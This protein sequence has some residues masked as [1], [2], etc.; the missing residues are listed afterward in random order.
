[1]KSS[2][3]VIAVGVALSLSGCSRP[4]IP[5][6]GLSG[7]PSPSG[8]FS[9]VASKEASASGIIV[10]VEVARRPGGSGSQLRVTT[11]VTG[12]SSTPVELKTP[13]G[14]AVL[15]TIR[16]LETSEAVFD[17]R[18][19]NAQAVASNPGLVPDESEALE[20]D[21]SRSATYQSAVLRPGRYELTAMTFGPV[22]SIE[23]LTLTID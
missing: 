8:S 23:A 18:V 7:K 14:L 12:D 19:L 1:V 5:A 11:S 15:V 10:G 2:C 9:V 21:S 4:S 3:L 13:G 22:V 16:S 6:P 20:Q 17:S